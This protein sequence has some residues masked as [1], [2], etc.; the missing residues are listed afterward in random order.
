ME[1]EKG[2]DKNQHYKIFCEKHRPFK[3]VKELEERDRQTVDEVLK[4]AKV[5]SKC[6]EISQRI[7]EKN[8]RTKKITP[9]S[10][11]V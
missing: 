5:I 3:I 1:I 7:E 10:K 9:F 11:N 2:Q 6:T 8:N 4:F